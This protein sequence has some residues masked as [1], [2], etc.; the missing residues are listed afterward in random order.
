MNYEKRPRP[1]VSALLVLLVLLATA[2][3]NVT[4]QDPG[5][6]GPA[7]GM[8][9]Q[10]VGPLVGPTV[11]GTLDGSDPTFTRPQ[12]SPVVTVNC[13]SA[14]T[15]SAGGFRYEAHA[16][17]VTNNSPIQI[18]VNAAGTTIG[19]TFL[20]VSCHPFNAATPSV[21]GVITDDD[22]GAGLLSAITLADNVTLTPGKTY[23]AVITTYDPGATGAYQL[24]FS[25]NVVLG[26]PPKK[27]AWST[28]A[29]W[30]NFAPTA[31]NGAFTDGVAVYPDHLEG[32]AWAENAGWIRLGTHT[33]GGAWTYANTSATNYGVN[34]NPTTGALSGYAWSST[35]GWIKFDPAWQPLEIGS[36]D[37]ASVAPAN[38]AEATPQVTGPPTRLGPPSPVQ[39]S[40]QE[41]RDLLEAPSADVVRDGSFELG[42][43]NPFWSEASTNFGTPLCGPGCSSASHTGLWFAWF[44]GISVYEAG[45]VSQ[46]VTIPSGGP[47]TLSFWVKNSSC[48]GSA[49]DYLEVKVDG[50][51][52][53]VTTAADPACTTPGYRQ[54]TVDVSAYADDAAHVL[55]FH[56]EV[57]GPAIT[58]FFLDDVALNANYGAVVDGVGNFRGYAWSENLGWIKFSGTA[59]DATP[60]QAQVRCVI[61]VNA[62]GTVDVIDVQLVTSA[63]GLNVPAYDFNHDSVVNVADIQFVA[64]RWRVGC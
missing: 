28:N 6:K 46:S 60:Y 24:D 51:Q 31:P 50:A 57:F 41:L 44:G 33:S 16:F 20:I 59:G 12:N 64:N 14:W 19:D 54:V 52:R 53:W 23:W 36:T 11:N 55:Q 39:R 43:P 42:T 2:V 40:A 13:A 9:S 1:L 49:A 3:G 17:H 47:A 29:G 56:S 4:A 21:N 27:W 22:D 8:P 34:R 38:N 37:D 62:S 30:I 48:S 61:D 18:E 10:V 25:D 63:F 15:P 32:Y 58:N 5:G 45:S 7:A 26:V 35:S